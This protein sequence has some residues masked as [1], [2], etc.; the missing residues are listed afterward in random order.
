MRD[1][2]IYHNIVKNEDGLTEL[3]VNMLQFPSF[4]DIFTQFITDKFNF[5]DFLFD[6]GDVKTQQSLGKLGRPDLVIENKL[7]CIFIECKIEDY[8]QLTPNQPKG[9][10]KYLAKA[11]LS[12]KKCALLFLVPYYYDHETSI[13]TQ[14]SD[15]FATTPNANVKLKI[16]YWPELIKKSE[17]AKIANENI[18]LKHFIKLL[19]AWFDYETITFSKGEF[20]MTKDKE[21]PMFFSKIIKLIQEVND[22]VLRNF[23]TD[24]LINEYGV[25][26]YIKNKQ[27]EYLLA[28]G[29]GF[30]PWQDYGSFFM[31]FV[32]DDEDENFSPNFVKRFKKKLGKE[33]KWHE[34]WQTYIYPLPQT[35]LEDPHNVK[36]IARFITEIAE[37][38]DG[39]SK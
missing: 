3:L 2:N 14:A 1:K 23:K 38:C 5:T 30:E 8:R 32:D 10:L 27:G 39:T 37:Y 20:L 16:G 25:F 11:K 6:Y 12:K 35:L 31:T 13:Q 28:F 19:H 15:F 36:K 17:T 34:D 33:V 29:C 26:Y 9:Y 4:K 18:A 21:I 24:E 7:F 22:K